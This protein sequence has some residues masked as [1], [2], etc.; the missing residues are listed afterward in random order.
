[1]SEPWMEAVGLAAGTLTT[2]S[3]L[4]QVVKTWRTKAV[5]DLSLRMYLSLSAGVTLWLVYGLCVGSLSIVVANG[6]TLALSLSI[7]VMKLRYARR[8]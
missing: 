5:R 2:L 1:M 3:F 4:P 8:S 7:L 6:L